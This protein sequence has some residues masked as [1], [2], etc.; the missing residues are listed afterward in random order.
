MNQ[1]DPKHER[2][3]TAM[4]ESDLTIIIVTFNSEDKIRNTDGSLFSEFNTIVVDNAS[5]DDTHKIISERFAGIK[6]IQNKANLGYARAN[7]IALRQTNTKYALVLNPDVVASADS[8]R[9]LI[10]IAD[11]H[12]EYSLIGVSD[13]A[14]TPHSFNYSISDADFVSGSCML[15]RMN[16]FSE[17]GFFDKDFFMYFEDVDLCVR[18]KEAG[19]RL[20]IVE[21]S[22]IIHQEGT[23][24]GN[25]SNSLLERF[26]IWGASA[27]C[28]YEKHRNHKEGRR[29]RKKILQWRKRKIISYILRDNNRYAEACARIKGYED[30]KRSGASISFHNYFTENEMRTKNIDSAGFKQTAKKA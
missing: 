13:H 28:F 30:V 8:I 27:R 20:G 1:L 3:R 2:K 22:S 23:S 12:P 9:K 10:D 17:I 25:K 21:G 6:Y 29:A 18:L 24:T 16:D 7:N 15:F 4:S 5:K 14:S 19:Y 11:A 26:W